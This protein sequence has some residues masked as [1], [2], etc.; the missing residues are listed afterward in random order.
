MP[1]VEARSWNRFIVRKFAVMPELLGANHNFIFQ[2]K[3]IELRVPKETKKS[4]EKVN[5]SE[6]DA[7]TWKAKDVSLYKIR[8]ID[9]LIDI[10]ED[11]DIPEEALRTSPRRG[12]LLSSKQEA[13]LDSISAEHSDIAKSALKYW[14]SIMR[15]KTRNADLGEPQ[16]ERNESGWST[17]LISTET[18][19]PFWASTYWISGELYIGITKAQ[20]NDIQKTLSD[21]ITPPPW[22]DFIFEAI[23]HLKNYDPVAA[24]LNAAIAHEL[25]LRSLLSLHLS[26]ESSKQSIISK[27]LDRSNLRT[28]ENHRKIMSIWDDEWERQYDNSDFNK[29][30][31]SR[32]AIMHRA[33][34][35]EISK[36]D[37]KRILNNLLNFAYFVDEKT[38][39][40]T[41]DIV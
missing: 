6:V 13:Y 12:E 23:L 2:G 37:W 1:I 22:F 40:L 10:G 7:I 15:W 35:D 34:L 21:K 18:N 5:N 30:M 19:H 16:I 25:I 24:I 32:D 11:L 39:H 28:I 26:S 27:I 4:D 31:N 14:L 29:L 17:R 8:S 41:K 20:W 38:E 33:A 3:P 36:H 9:I